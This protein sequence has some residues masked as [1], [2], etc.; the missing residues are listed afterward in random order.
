MFNDISSAASLLAEMLSDQTPQGERELPGAV[1]RRDPGLDA[2]VLSEAVVAVAN[3]GGGGAAVAVAGDWDGR[4]DAGSTPAVP[5]PP[6]S[7]DGVL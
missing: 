2:H 3:C 6:E 4:A 1:A 7:P 5:L